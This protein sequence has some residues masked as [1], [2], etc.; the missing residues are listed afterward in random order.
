LVDQLEIEA[1]VL[2]LRQPVVLFLPKEDGSTD[3]WKL[4]VVI[5]SWSPLKVK[6]F[7]DAAAEVSLPEDRKG[8][9]VVGRGRWFYAAAGWDMRGRPFQPDRP[10]E[11]WLAFEN[12]NSRQKFTEGGVA[13]GGSDAFVG[14]TE[15]EVDN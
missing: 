5:G 4:D 11:V 6:D 13:D 7:M 10:V 8:I 3:Q 14:F 2:N 9:V 12:I 1:E 15:E